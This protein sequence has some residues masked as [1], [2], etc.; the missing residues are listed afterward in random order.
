MVLLRHKPVIASVVYVVDLQPEQPRV[1]L[2]IAD[3]QHALLATRESDLD[4]VGARIEIT[5]RSCTVLCADAP[6]DP[7][8]SSLRTNSDLRVGEC[9][10]A[11]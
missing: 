6:L 1:G 2:L 5:V 10:A 4:A 8:V 11:I 3:N 9:I 7:H